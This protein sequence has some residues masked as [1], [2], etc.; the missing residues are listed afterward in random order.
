M[1]KTQLVEMAKHNITH[2]LA[3]TINLVDDVLRVPASHY[4]DPE[5]WRLEMDKL[6]KRVPL[7]LAMSCELANPGDYKSMD[8]VGMPV[9]LSRGNNGELRA[10]VNMCSHRGSMIMPEGGGNTHRF[11]CPYHAWSYD[12]IGALISVFAPDDFR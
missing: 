6:F 2:T 5:R 9:L 1:S 4:Y 8:A 10:F 12:H 3:G 11:T 7:M